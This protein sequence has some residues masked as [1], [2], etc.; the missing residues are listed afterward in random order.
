M[1][2]PLRDDRELREAPVKVSSERSAITAVHRVA[3]TAPF[4]LRAANGRLN[5]HPSPYPLLQPLWTDG[6]DHPRELVTKGD[7]W[8]AWVT[9][10]DDVQVSSADSCGVNRDPDLTEA[11][12]PNG[13]LAYEQ[14]TT[15]RLQL[16]QCSH[17][18]R[19]RELVR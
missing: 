3:D 6:V 10:V 16:P 18:H 14:F 19:A 15:S 13:H 11:R 1:E 2:I 8:K 5:G 4:T 7:R 17:E 9:A 12:L